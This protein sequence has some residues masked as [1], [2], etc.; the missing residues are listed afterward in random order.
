[1]LVLFEGSTASFNASKKHTNVNGNMS[2][3][4]RFEQASQPMISRENVTT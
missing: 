1:M 3:I 2:N 4:K